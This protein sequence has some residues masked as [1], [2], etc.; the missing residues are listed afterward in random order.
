MKAIRNKDYLVTVSA[1]FTVLVSDVDADCAAQQAASI[2]TTEMD[3]VE[4]EIENVEQD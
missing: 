1:T 3:L 4:M 2:P